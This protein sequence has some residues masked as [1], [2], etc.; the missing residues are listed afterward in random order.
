MTNAVVF[1]EK[2]QVKNRL[3]EVILSALFVISAQGALLAGIAIDAKRPDGDA[4]AVV[5]NA[6]DAAYK[7][8]GGMVRLSAG[9]WPMGAIR[10]RSRVTLYLRAG[11]KIVGSRN[12]EEYF[13]L[14]RDRLEPVEANLISHDRWM[15]SDSQDRDTLTRLP[16]CRWN[17]ALIRAFRATDVAIIGETGSEINGSNPYDPLGEERYR[18]PLG[19]N[20]TDCTN[21]VLK[22]YT[23]GD[24]G[25]W[26]HRLCD[27][28]GLRV[29]NVTCLGGHD[30]VHIKGCDDVVIEKCI[31]KTG[32]DCVAGFD[33]WNVTVRD[34][35]INSSCSAFR[36][37]G[38]GVLIERCK[39]VGPGE[40]GFRGALSLEEKKAGVSTPP[41]SSLGR[42]NMLSFFTYYADG[43]HPIREYPGKIVIRDC[44]VE[45]ADRFL[46]YNYNNERWQ[47]GAPMR[48]ITFERVTA[49]GIKMPLNAYGQDSKYGYDFCVP[50]DLTLRDCSIS[51]SADVPEFI[52]GANV[53][54]LTLENVN[55]KGVTG[56]LLRTWQGETDVKANNLKGVGVD[57]EKGHGIWNAGAI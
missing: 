18:G 19:I 16:G 21:A 7:A 44:T 25:N 35:Y 57:V 40:W 17:N 10:L 22:G 26:A 30:A 12:V 52:R 43:T 34:C 42:N 48:D 47:S 24:T 53:R 54:S 29:E 6:I 23:I 38:T 1:R 9:E 28:K 33:N 14:E 8:G 13:I 4:T 2:Q 37:A 49:K 51:F 56:P 41:G 50:L 20:F 55:V 32:D 15:R 31:F 27:V 5:Q 45:N 46:H 3:H 36:F 39:I 11:A